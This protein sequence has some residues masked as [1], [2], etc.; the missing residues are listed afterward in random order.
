MFWSPDTTYAPAGIGLRAELVILVANH[1]RNSIRRGQADAVVTADR[2]YV[3]DVGQ[4]L[5]EFVALIGK[6]SAS[7]ESP[8]TAEILPFNSAI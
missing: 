3:H 7:A 2:R 5:D 1:Q 6:G 4:L 8:G